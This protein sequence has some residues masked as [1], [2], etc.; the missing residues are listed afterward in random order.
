MSNAKVLTFAGSARRDS[1]NK[2]LSQ[3][4]AD[5]AKLAARR[6]LD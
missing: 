2:R 1:L 4:A 6:D 5:R 3:V